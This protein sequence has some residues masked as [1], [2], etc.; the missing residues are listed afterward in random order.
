M[1]T[2]IPSLALFITLHT[3]GSVLSN[4]GIT[5]ECGVFRDWHDHCLL[6]LYG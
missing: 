5:S 1:V 4:L 2:W 3:D 6:E